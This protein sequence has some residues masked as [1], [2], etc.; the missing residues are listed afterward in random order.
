MAADVSD[1][2]ADELSR[3][4]VGL[5]SCAFCMSTLRLPVMGSMFS[6]SRYCRSS[7]ELSAKVGLEVEVSMS[8]SRW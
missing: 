6:V 2:T 3:G 5:R 8:E 7:V 4:C 1:M